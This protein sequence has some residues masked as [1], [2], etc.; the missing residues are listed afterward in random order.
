MADVRISARS[1]L[2]TLN[3][4]IEVISGNLVGSQ[5]IGYKGT[6]IS[7]GDSLVDVIR[8]GAG[9]TGNV[10]GINP[11]QISSGGI[12][13]GGTTTDY[14]QGSLIQTGN[15][16]DLSIQGNSFFTMADSSG[17]IIYTR[18]GEFSFDD[19]GYLVNKEGSF[20]LGLYDRTREIINKAELE[21]INS[22]GTGITAQF[23]I[24]L[25]GK[26]A[27]AGATG[28]TNFTG[29]FGT[30]VNT[31]LKYLKDPA[32]TNQDRIVADQFVPAGQLS[33]ATATLSTTFIGATGY[34]IGT[35]N[36]TGIK[37]TLADQLN[38]ATRTSLDNAK[39]IANAINEQ[40]INTGVAAS[41]VVNL[42]DQNQATIVL[43]HV[44]RIIAES[45]VRMPTDP[46]AQNIEDTLT[47]NETGLIRTYKDNKNNIFFAINSLSLFG[48]SPEYR[49]EPGD[50]FN[51]NQT[52]EL[53]N[54][55]KGKDADSA[56]PFGTGIHVAVTKFANAQGLER[57]RGGSQFYYTEAT[58]GIV[59]GFAGLSRTSQI[60]SKL[61]IEENGSSS[62]GV[63]NVIISQALESSNTSVTDALPELTVAQKTFTSNTKVV[64]VGNTIVDDL[65]GL[66]R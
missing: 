43:G 1:T 66:I 2:G 39:L 45:S 22:G 51:F 29:L 38:V 30:G 40:S 64:N 54:N 65:N 5:I 33:Q 14:K 37:I 13:V 11:V 63:E 31:I 53:I 46:A 18:A 62:I 42:N 41:V 10:G 4:W 35:I 48:K 60:S 7:F 27:N 32:Q 50:V 25:F 12:S 26:D 17:K 8:G 55:S 24:D 34:T 47:T 23:A 9:A 36:G 6:R 49:P 21:D 15:N 44:N 59:V 28:T 52:G 19:Q 58:G 61:G 3:R 16:L 57:R 20:V 56:P